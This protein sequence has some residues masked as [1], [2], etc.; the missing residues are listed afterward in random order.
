MELVEAGLPDERPA[1]LPSSSLMGFPH[2]QSSLNA[3]R[4][5]D[6][7]PGAGCS[8]HISSPSFQAWQLIL[9]LPKP[10][11]SPLPLTRRL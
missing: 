7:S 3:L 9:F 11:A 8:I 1:G 6:V 2:V 4:R 5:V 10:G